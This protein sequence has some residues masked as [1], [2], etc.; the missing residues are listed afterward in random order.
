MALMCV[1]TG[2]VVAEP[3]LKPLELRITDHQAGIE[4]F[5]RLGVSLESV[6]IHRKG[7]PRKQGWTTLIGNVPCVDIVPLKNGLYTSISTAQIPVAQYDAI[8][9]RFQHL[10]GVLH[11]GQNPDLT[12]ES[13]TVLV[14]IDMLS[15]ISPALVLDLYVESQTDHAPNKYVV[16]VK[17]IRVES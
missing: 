17:E 9:V 2:G 12:A 4:E 11:S 5:K 10:D 16:K 13:T 1:V 3:E 7:S 6:E 14:P 8:R 15:L